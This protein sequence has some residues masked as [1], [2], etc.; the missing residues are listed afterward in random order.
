MRFIIFI[1]SLPLIF[2]IQTQLSSQTLQIPLKRI[3]L[4]KEEKQALISL[5]SKSQS[6]PLRI[7]EIGNASFLSLSSQTTSQ[8]KLKNYA[9][10]QFVGQVGVGNPAQ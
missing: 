1:L 2:S 8:I 5:V 6:T 7:A 9:N 3:A 4:N 10:T